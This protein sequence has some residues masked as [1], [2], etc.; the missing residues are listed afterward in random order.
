MKIVIVDYRCG[1]SASIANA[2]KYL[3]YSA[4]LSHHEKDILTCDRLIF[5]GVGS[6]GQGINHLIKLNL[7]PILKKTILTEQV[8]TL[9]I[10]LG[11]QLML[12]SSEEFSLKPGLGLVEGKVVKL[13]TSNNIL[14]PH[15]GWNKV[16]IVHQD[17]NIVKQSC[18]YFAHSYY[19]KLENQ[20]EVT[21]TCEYGGVLDVAYKKNNIYGCQFHP[22]KSQ[23]DGIDY[24]SNFLDQTI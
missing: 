24:L 1:N 16:K 17:R 8:P 20:E 22:E 13:D 6:F 23:K 18:V 7:I 19:M 14:V 10:C 3:G 15:I 2:I 4:I 11:A 5:P 12:E 21:A 9:G